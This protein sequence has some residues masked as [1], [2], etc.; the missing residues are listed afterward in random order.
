MSVIQFNLLPDVKLEYIKAKRLK[1]LTVM[2]AIL[3]AGSCLVIAVLLYLAVNVGQKKHMN[4]LNTD[5]TTAA[6]KV[7]NTP[8]INKIITVQNQLTSLPA[9]HD[10]K[11]AATRLFNYLAQ[12][13]PTN[14]T[15]SNV[16]VDFVGD[17]FS[18]SGSANDLLG[19]N[20]FVDTLKFTKY[21]DKTAGA[22]P[23]NAF[24]KVLLTGFSTN[25]KGATYQVTM[26]FNP[27]IF[28]NQKTID[29]T[30]P[31][32]ITTRSQVDQPGALFQQNAVKQG[33][34]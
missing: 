6:K 30:V 16:L 22:Q 2:I 27:D 13:T 11:P 29:F 33:G 15:Y 1:S 21:T 20:T 25:D 23:A 7:Q 14:V 9:L 5:I 19:V 24:S 18:I 17:T 26:S 28:N 31:K 32:T 8:D 3:F 10:G 12:V 4:D 34:Q